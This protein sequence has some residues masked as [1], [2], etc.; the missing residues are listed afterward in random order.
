MPF[1]S[2]NPLGDAR[3]AVRNAQ[4][5]TR[6]I[7]SMRLTPLL[8]LPALL[9][10]CA[11]DTVPSPDPDTALPFFGNGYRSEDDP[12]RRVGESPETVDYLDHTADLVGCPATM[13][14]LNGFVAETGAIEAFEQDGYKVFSI[15]RGI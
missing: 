15:P 14:N 1:F 8:L 13:E 3:R 4:S 7:C 5:A 12:C 11:S 10:G 9:A 2:S 6:K